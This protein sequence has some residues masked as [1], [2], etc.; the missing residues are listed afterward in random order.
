MSIQHVSKL[1]VGMAA[2]L[3]TAAV[4]YATPTTIM[5]SYSITQTGTAT[6]TNDLA[7]PFTLVLDVGTP[8]APVDFFHEVETT[9]GASTI[10]ATFTFNEPTTGNGSIG[11][12]D[13]FT[14]T[15]SARHDTLT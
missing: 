6:I 13:I 2:Y 1:L 15:G 3:A 8:T 4:A 5:G 9:G 12:S 14:V 10:T 7:D 11:A